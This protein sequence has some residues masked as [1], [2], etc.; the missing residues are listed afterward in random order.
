M[1]GRHEIGLLPTWSGA[2]GRSRSPGG[3]ARRDGDEPAF[4]LGKDSGVRDA[5][6][7]TATAAAAEPGVQSRGPTPGLGCGDERNPGAFTP[8]SITVHI[9]RQ[10]CAVWMPCKCRSQTRNHCCGD[11]QAE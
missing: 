4:L 1:A 10:L 3:T 8:K 9:C 5:P 6:L 2:P 7:R 11:K